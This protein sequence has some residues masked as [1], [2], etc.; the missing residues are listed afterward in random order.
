MQFGRRNGRR[1]ITRNRSPTHYDPP[2]FLQFW[3]HICD[4]QGEQK[5]LDKRVKTGALNINAP[6]CYIQGCI[7]VPVI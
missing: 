7:V 2:T 3:F 4:S 6:V 1:L 5:H